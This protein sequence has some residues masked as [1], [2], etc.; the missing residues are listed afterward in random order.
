MSEAGAR[1]GHFHMSEPGLRPVGTDPAIHAPIARALGR[2]S[3]RGWVSVEMKASED[4][5]SALRIAYE[6]AA[7]TYGNAR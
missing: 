3:Y 6:A 7:T 1:I 5:Q 2:S 4:W